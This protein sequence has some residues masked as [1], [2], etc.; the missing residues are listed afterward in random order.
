MQTKRNG[1]PQ[2]TYTGVS[3]YALDPKPEDFNILDIAH[4]LSLKCRFGG[5]CDDFYSVA[6][7]S[8]LICDWFLQSETPWL[9]FQGLMHD[10]AEAYFLGDVVTPLKRHLGKKYITVEEKLER[11]IC[12]KYGVP[13]PFSKELKDVDGR[14][15]MTEKNTLFSVSRNWSENFKPLPITLR[16]YSSKEAEREFLKRFGELS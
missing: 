1:S 2:Q 15:L 16:M 14:I 5:M 12:K 8:I 7:H 9:A 6:E 3:F 11:M 4:S 10:S 13:Y